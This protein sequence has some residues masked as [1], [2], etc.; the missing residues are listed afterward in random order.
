M[1]QHISRGTIMHS[2][3][4]YT[5]LKGVLSDLTGIP[6]AD[7]FSDQNLPSDLKFTPAG[8]FGLAVDLNKAFATAQQAITPPLHGDETTAATIVR[9]LRILISGR[10]K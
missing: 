10:V 6:R 8:L 5:I 3:T 9:D 1:R 7:I 4:I 2:N